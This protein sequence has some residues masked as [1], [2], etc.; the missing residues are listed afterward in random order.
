MS[1]TRFGR[2]Q[3]HPATDFRSKATFGVATAA[4]L[5]MLPMGLYDLYRGETAIGIGA[6]AVV[7]ALLANAWMARN[8][9]CHQNLTAFGLMPAGMVFM[10]SIFQMDGIIASFWCFPIVLAAYCMLS[11]RRAWA[12]NGMILI[13]ALPMA[14]LTLEAEYALR[15]TASLGAVSLFAAIMVNVI[16]EQ[17]RQL[18]EQLVLD[19]LTG[20]LNR[21]TFTSCMEQSVRLHSRY[22]QAVS[23]LAVDI[24][25]FKQLNDSHGHAAGDQVLAMTGH[26]MRDTLREEDA[27]FRMG[28]EEFTVVLK[29]ANENAALEAAE[30]LRVVLAT[31]SFSNACHI[32]VSIGVAEH[33]IGESWENWAKR[34]DDSLY[35]AKHQGRDQVVINRLRSVDNHQSIKL[36][37]VP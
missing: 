21:L 31:A 28:G 32:T 13:I 37:S 6:L 26:L 29:G 36:V 5:L 16:D 17:R 3:K 10:I 4:V 7:F 34:A 24:D 20:L 2:E 9:Y 19:P 35:E 25:H 30:R 22:D 27:I 14:W 15:V 18:H 1:S 33:R 23:L 12:V 8:G 11:E